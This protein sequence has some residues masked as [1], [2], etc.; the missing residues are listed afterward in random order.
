MAGT[1]RWI[2]ARV[3]VSNLGQQHFFKKARPECRLMS[4]QL[5][6]ATRVRL[7]VPATRPVASACIFIRVVYRAV[8]AERALSFFM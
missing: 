2:I 7:Y 8:E 4:L 5:A 6:C 3:K 1:L